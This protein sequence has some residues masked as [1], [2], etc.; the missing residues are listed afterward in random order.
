MRVKLHSMVD[1]ITNSSSVIYTYSDGALNPVKEL[2]QE[3][4]K[5][6]GVDENVDDVF[7]IQIIPDM[8][9]L[10]DQLSDYCY[11]LE[12][13]DDEP[14]WMKEYRNLSY[15]E[16]EAF[17]KD[18]YTKNKEAGVDEGWMDTEDDQM[19]TWLEITA[20]KEKYKVLAELLVKT[21][22]SIET[23]EGYN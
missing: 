18:R 7:D 14:E 5:V 11:D 20:K 9:R 12:G 15:K 4:F 22:Y 16:K 1:V 6:F 2:F 21:V 17:V 10:F 19:D 13:D 3:M 23:E 8:G